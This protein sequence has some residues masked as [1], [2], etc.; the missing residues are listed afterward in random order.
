MK[1]NQAVLI[2]TPSYSMIFFHQYLCITLQEINKNV[3]R[4]CSP[5]LHSSFAKFC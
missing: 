4:H 3:D 5:L 2:A 1:L